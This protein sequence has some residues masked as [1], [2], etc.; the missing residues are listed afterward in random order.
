MPCATKFQADLTNH[1]PVEDRQ[2]E[3]SRR[4]PKSA[5]DEEKKVIYTTCF[6]KLTRTVSV[7]SF[8]P[9]IDTSHQTAPRTHICKF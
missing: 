2:Q 3:R 7:C 9:G 1:R 8:F 5:A 4:G 6:V